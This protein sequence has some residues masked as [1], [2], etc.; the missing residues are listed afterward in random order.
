M[1]RTKGTK[2]AIKKLSKTLPAAKVLAEMHKSDVVENRCAI[3]ILANTESPWIWWWFIY[4]GSLFL[5]QHLKP[6]EHKPDNS[7][8]GISRKG[9]KPCLLCITKHFRA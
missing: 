1:P 9:E 8:K 7:D 6:S 5:L 3:F 2:E 4:G